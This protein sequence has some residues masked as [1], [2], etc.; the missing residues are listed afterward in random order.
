M[1]SDGFA[2]IVASLDAG[3]LKAS[4]FIQAVEDRVNSSLRPER[5]GDG[6]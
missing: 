4:E 5:P 2:K 6:D 1:E 3:D